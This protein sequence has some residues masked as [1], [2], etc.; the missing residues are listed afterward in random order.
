MFERLFETI[1]QLCKERGT[2][3]AA[4]ERELRFSSASI[5]KWV[6]S[7]P[8]LDKV[9]KVAEYFGVPVDYLIFGNQKTAHPANEM[10]RQDMIMKIVA[11]FNSLGPEDRKFA[12]GLLDTI[13]QSPKRDT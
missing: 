5:R 12:L 13:L 9:V 6:S 4:L 8:S 1:K 11:M 2:T 10:S 3:V 7:P